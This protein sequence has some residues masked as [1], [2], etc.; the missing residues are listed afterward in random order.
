ML[1]MRM[2]SSFK[3]FFQHQVSR[4]CSVHMKVYICATEELAVALHQLTTVS[5]FS[6][7]SLV[8]NYFFSLNFVPPDLW[9][10]SPEV[11]RRRFMKVCAESS[12]ATGTG[13]MPQPLFAAM[14]LER[15]RPPTTPTHP[16]PYT[17]PLW[18]F[19]TTESHMQCNNGSLQDFCISSVFN[20]RECAQVCIP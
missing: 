17:H 16:T 9:R 13:W 18:P 2:H 5:S 3:T 1:K 8:Q 15:L 12:P 6:F 14:P 20:K 11:V 19:I 4:W 7:D 10:D